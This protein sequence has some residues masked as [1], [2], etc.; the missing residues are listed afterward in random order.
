MRIYNVDMLGAQERVPRSSLLLARRVF[1]LS[2]GGVAETDGHVSLVLG[3]VG[4]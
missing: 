1:K 2:M 3:N 4:S